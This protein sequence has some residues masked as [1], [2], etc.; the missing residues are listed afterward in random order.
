M[1]KKKV[2]LVGAL[3]LALAALLPSGCAQSLSSGLADFESEK[4]IESAAADTSFPSAA[5][6]GVPPSSL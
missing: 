2:R 4:A 3:A 1:S 6:A 5:E